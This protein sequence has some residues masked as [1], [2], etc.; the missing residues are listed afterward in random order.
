MLDECD[1]T[2][3]PLPLINLGLATLLEERHDEALACFRHGLELACDLGHVVPEVY[4]LLGVAVVLA[5]MGEAEEAAM[6]AGAT[7]AAARRP[8]SRSSPSERRILEEAV[9][10]LETTLGAEAF[11]A[12]WSAGR[13][14]T[15]M[16]A[17]ARIHAIEPA[18][19]PARGSY[20]PI[21]W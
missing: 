15:I 6:I 12:A 17:S 1:P 21:E 16:E 4:C 2:G 19:R 5:A 11:S 7:E 14:L 13:E 10:V 8:A 3:F 9:E 20:M 18:A